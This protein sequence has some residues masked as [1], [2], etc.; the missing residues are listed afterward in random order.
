[1][2]TDAPE[3]HTRTFSRSAVSRLTGISERQIA[4]ICET[5]G[6]QIRRSTGGNRQ[7]TTTN[8]FDIAHHMREITD[9]KAQK[10]K[11]TTQ[12]GMIRPQKVILVNVGKGGTGK[13][14]FCSNLATIA[15]LS[16]IKTCVIDVDWQSSCTHIFG[17]TPDVTTAIARRLN[18]TEEGA[19]DYTLADLLGQ[20]GRKVIPFS[21]VAKYP[22]GTNGPM[23][24]PSN[25]ELS[26]LDGQLVATRLT[27]SRWQFTLSDW[28]RQTP[29]MQGYEL[30]VIDSGPGYSPVVD[31]ALYA[32]DLVLAPVL[33]ESVTERA[34]SKLRMRLDEI[35]KETGQKKLLRIAPNR[36][37][38]T[39][40][41]LD[42]LTFINSIYKGLL[43]SNFID[44]RAD[45]VKSYSRGISS[46]QLS[47]F[48]FQFPTADVTRSLQAI[49]TTL[50]DH[51]WPEFQQD[52]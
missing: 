30:I 24:I 44:N 42:E 52:K 29:E 34:L 38:N 9:K 20:T 25:E 39:Q 12:R 35:H 48:V 6:L 1:M 2:N 13:S 19:I 40:R 36:M 45:V 26:D 3:L 7:Y 5:M 11:G 28:L 22:F 4:T 15:A 10:E 41:E 43:L 8:I 49:T 33:L 16:G 37:T 51:L 23:L 50:C 32:A 31:T 17:Y 21:Q 46:D 14:F 47:P 27:K 18:I